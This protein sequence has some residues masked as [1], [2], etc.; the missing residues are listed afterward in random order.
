MKL[1]PEGRRSFMEN[2]LRLI[3][4][5]KKDAA[6]FLDYLTISK[7]FLICS[8]RF[9]IYRLDLK[10]D[11][12]FNDESRPVL[13]FV[14]P[15]SY[16]EKLESPFIMPYIQVQN[17]ID[18]LKPQYFALHTDDNTTYEDFKQ[19]EKLLAKS[20]GKIAL[21]I[22]DQQNEARFV[23][24]LSLLPHKSLKA[25]KCDAEHLTYPKLV[26]NLDLDYLC[27]TELR[28][29]GQLKDVLRHK[30][31]VLQIDSINEYFLEGDDETSVDE[32]QSKSKF[33]ESLILNLD[34]SLGEFSPI[35]EEIVGTFPNL[36]SLAVNTEFID[37]ESAQDFNPGFV[38]H[39][40]THYY[41]TIES[42]KE[43]YSKLRKVEINMGLKFVTCLCEFNP[44]LFGVFL[45]L[46][47]IKLG[48]AKSRFEKDPDSGGAKNFIVESKVENP[49]FSS[50]FKITIHCGK[51]DHRGESDEDSE[52]PVGD[53][54]EQGTN[55]DI[56]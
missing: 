38:Y 14:P 26:P 53:A 23:R 34:V 15:K 16:S 9:S 22:H 12:D 45:V 33:V 35:V 1:N 29:I 46:E 3:I 31:K 27:L 2:S 18:L 8:Y 17:L 7:G 44:F 30:V 36:K 48:K 10:E 39:V 19:Q 47:K 13:C 32:D 11:E 55:M 24:Q 6:K 42:L 5:G 4:S 51:C 20:N 56:D 43:K 28:D 37:E 52:I 41:D 40:T 21:F 50:N 54:N 49:S 25:L